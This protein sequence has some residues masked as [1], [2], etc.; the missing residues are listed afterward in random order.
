MSDKGIGF[1]PTELVHRSK[2]GQVGWGLFSI[3]ERLTLLGGRFDI[4][5]APQRGTQFRLIAPRGVT[6][7]VAIESTSAGT[8]S[9]APAR[10]LRILIA[11][12]HPGVREAFREML[13][14]RREL[15]VVG[16]AADGLE[17]IAKAHELRPD[18]I[19]MDVS[20]PVM[21][22]V[23]ATRRVRAE[24]PFIQVLGLSTYTRADAQAIELAGAAGFY[25][26]LLMRSA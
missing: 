1:D 17:A 11:D 9:N 3:R 10:A 16:E 18:V 21:D 13:E 19:L 25:S 4:D 24:L 5:S 20:M 8:V 14:E 23:Q 26:R 15:R 2:A 22:G 6:E 7:A 12:D